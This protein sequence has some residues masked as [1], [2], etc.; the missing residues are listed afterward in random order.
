MN[1][2]GALKE[3][4]QKIVAD[5]PKAVKELQE[6]NEKTMAFFVGQAMRATQGKANPKMVADIVKELI[7]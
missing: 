1:D 3:I 4:L 2:T 7:K 5:N 6:G